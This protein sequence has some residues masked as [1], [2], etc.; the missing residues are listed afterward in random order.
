MGTFT[1]LFQKYSVLYINSVTTHI[2]DIII[3]IRVQNCAQYI[4]NQTIFLI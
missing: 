3:E 1:E 4:P 2:F